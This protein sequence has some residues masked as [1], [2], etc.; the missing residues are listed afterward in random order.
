MPKIS[1]IK[2]DIYVIA[3]SNVV[4]LFLETYLFSLTFLFLYKFKIPIELCKRG[5]KKTIFNRVTGK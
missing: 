1:Q 5:T 4:N 3:Y 2:N